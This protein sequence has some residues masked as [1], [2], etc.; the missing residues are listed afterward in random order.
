VTYII[1]VK[2]LLPCPRKSRAN[3]RKYECV[4]EIDV[5]LQQEE[6]AS[7]KGGGAWDA[8]CQPPK[9]LPVQFRSLQYILTSPSLSSGK[10]QEPELAARI[11]SSRFERASS[12]FEFREKI[13]A[14]RLKREF[15]LK[16]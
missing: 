14:L 3:Q 11:L 2:E 10:N 12:K 16:I 6:Q 1:T 15:A 7:I 5:E 4:R 9:E 8:F 13:Q